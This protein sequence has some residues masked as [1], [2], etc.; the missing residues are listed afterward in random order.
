M[1]E[2]YVSANDCI[3]MNNHTICMIHLGAFA[4]YT[5]PVNFCANEYFH[6]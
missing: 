2:D 5:A 6:K 3:A 1:P 4:N